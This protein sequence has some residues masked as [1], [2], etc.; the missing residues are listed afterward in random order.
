[1]LAFFFF[2][3][4]EDVVGSHKKNLRQFSDFYESFSGSNGRNCWFGTLSI[5][6]KFIP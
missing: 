3:L 2:F 6:L 5:L 4:F 1:M